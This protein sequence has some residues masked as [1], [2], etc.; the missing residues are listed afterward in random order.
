MKYKT[1]VSAITL[2]LLTAC[3]TDTNIK[4]TSNGNTSVDTE[5]VA[6]I[7]NNIQIFGS[8]INGEEL[9]VKYDYFDPNGDAQDIA[10][11]EVNWY[12]DNRLISTLNNVTLSNSEAS[13]AIRVAIKP[14]AL[15][16]QKKLDS[17]K[18]IKYVGSF[19]TDFP[20]NEDQPPFVSSVA[21][22]GNIVEG[23]KVNLSYSFIDTDLDL[24]GDSIVSWLI[25]KEQV[26]TGTEFTIPTNA[27]GKVLSVLIKPIALTGEHKLEGF[28]QEHIGGYIKSDTDTLPAQ[29]TDISISGDLKV[30]EELSLNYTY[31][32]VDV[33]TKPEIKW[34]I[35]GELIGS[36]RSVKL[37]V[38]ALAK[39]LTVKIKPTIDISL[40]QFDTQEITYYAGVV[41]DI[42]GVTP[43]PS[44]DSA[45]R[46]LSLSIDGKIIEGNQVTADYT[47]FDLNNDLEGMTEFQWFLDQELAGIH[48]SFVIPESS[49]GKSLKLVVTAKAISGENK[50]KSYGVTRHAGMI[51]HKNDS[52]VVPPEM[53]DS[54]PIVFGMDII[55]KGYEESKVS[56][57]YHYFDVNGDKE[58][59]SEISWQLD[60]NTVGFGPS[61]VIPAGSNG[62]MLSYKIKP[63]SATGENRANAAVYMYSGM[64]VLVNMPPQALTNDLVTPASKK[65]AHSLT[66]VDIDGDPLEFKIIEQP[67]FG[68]VEVIDER[69]G[70]ITYDA[71]IG[72]KGADVFEYSVSD[73]KSSVHKIVTVNVS[74][75]PLKNKSPIGLTGV[76]SVLPEQENE[77]TL[78]GYD[79][80]GD[81]LHYFISSGPKKGK[82][83]LMNSSSGVFFYT[84]DQDWRGVDT[85][86]YSVSDGKSVSSKTLLIKVI[87]VIENTKPIALS[88]NFTNIAETKMS[89][90]LLSYDDKPSLITYSIVEGVNVGQMTLVDNKKGIIEYTP[91]QNY[92]GKAV[93]KYM[94]SDGEYEDTS[95]VTIDV[96]AKENTAPNVPQGALKSI[97]TYVDTPVT[98]ELL[99]FDLNGD[100]VNYG[101]KTSVQNGDLTLNNSLT[102]DFTYTPLPAF[103]GDDSF[104]Y[105]IRDKDGESEQEVVIHVL[106]TPKDEMPAVGTTDSLKV[107][108]NVTS[109]LFLTA[110][111]YNNDD[112]EFKIVVPPQNAELILLPMKDPKSGEVMINYTPKLN[113]IGKDAFS[114]KVFDGK[115]ESV[116][117]HVDV[118]VV[119][120]SNANELPVATLV[121]LEIKKN[122]TNLMML[123]GYDKEGAPLTF[124]II[125]QPENAVIKLLDE[126]TG[127]ITVNYN[128][129]QPNGTFKYA[130]SD[131]VNTVTGQVNVKVLNQVPVLTQN[132]FIVKNEEKLKGKFDIR[133]PDGDSLYVSVNS[134]YNNASFTVESDGSFSYRPHPDFLGND[135]VSINISDGTVNDTY[136][137]FF[138]SIKT[139]NVIDIAT[140]PTDTISVLFE[141]GEVFEIGLVG[142]DSKLFRIKPQD[143]KGKITSMY[144]GARSASYVTENGEI[145]YFNKQYNYV[146][147]VLEEV[148]R[149]DDR[150]VE[151]PRNGLKLPI[152]DNLT[153]NKLMNNNLVAVTDAS[154]VDIDALTV[155]TGSFSEN[156]QVAKTFIINDQEAVLLNT[157][158]SLSINS[159]KNVEGITDQFDG[160]NPVVMV[161]T[162]HS[163]IAALHQNGAVTTFGN[164]SYGGDSSSI[165]TFLDGTVDIVDI[166]PTFSGFAFLNSDGAVMSN[167][168]ADITS[169]ASELN[170]TIPVVSVYAHKGGFAA[171]RS[172]NKVIFWGDNWF[173]FDPSRVDG[174][175]EI[176]DIQEIDGDLAFLFSDNTV[177]FYGANG[178]GNYSWDIL[179]KTFDGTNKPLSRILVGTPD[180]NEFF[181]TVIFEDGSVKTGLRQEHPELN[182]ILNDGEEL[183]QIYMTR[184]RILYLKNNGSLF[185]YNISS[186]TVERVF[187]GDFFEN[188]EV[189]KVAI[190]T[191]GDFIVLFKSGGVSAVGRNSR[192]TY[193]VN[194]LRDS[195]IGTSVPVNPYDDIDLD[196]LTN[197]DEQGCKNGVCFSI[198]EVDSDN[199]GVIDGQEIIN[200]TDP[201]IAEF[202][203]FKQDRNGD[204]YPDMW[205]FAHGNRINTPNYKM[206]K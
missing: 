182:A 52:E 100:T 95:I 9:H 60:D 116:E 74:D 39:T 153:M 93:F 103:S 171:L 49:A 28:P 55:G 185:N 183:K 150:L 160:T 42:N 169:V 162:N 137:V 190:L 147:N 125:T 10:K 146:G 17:V 2:A 123:T 166:K 8:V 112:L 72:F 140:N 195:L 177:Y 15:S 82:V 167:G 57:K 173:N 178:E 106:K 59:D 102:G 168:S 90:E 107:G 23:Q 170:G 117:K 45:P 127:K 78:S 139:G 197:G 142:R 134:S 149:P 121:E 188:E 119:T 94:V 99:S 109:K 164:K 38:S 30:G 152:V 179:N 105:T 61:F 135:R 37:P 34:L 108:A 81:V 16:G 118:D 158:G 12:A 154:I 26:G 206:T 175:K 80:N 136:S 131:G 56:V 159:V 92:V 11:S 130:V 83:S 132:K 47:Y 98:A 199:D 138:N 191:S 111:D 200:G 6:P 104:T 75:T 126:H 14:V 27:K 141:D 161:F 69:T 64:N 87:G 76:V 124:S 156:K 32:G 7:A 151:V 29:I 157:D 133:D 128:G 187:K 63:K 91:P 88:S 77:V 122:T 113:F 25:D 13:K 66:A 5:D 58:Q 174:T 204:G 194:M 50:D 53:I 180:G 203:H 43:P 184:D 18:K 65:I 89:H 67:K 86:E 35:D 44:T 19:H 193:K 129:G 46:I 114:Y 96:V 163:A 3:N 48:K 54:P 21:I 115:S 148:G 145:V 33:E 62:Q 97:S 85:L 22:N 84:P 41:K 71:K 4:K 165:S 1:I 201:L 40:N 51:G 120:D 198:S 189:E 196:G 143:A 205:K 202:D 70:D 68:M 79:E 110:Y 24:E 101:I 181:V 155:N 192:T 144:M 31:V 20:A 172:D 176:K 73:G 186:N 36:D